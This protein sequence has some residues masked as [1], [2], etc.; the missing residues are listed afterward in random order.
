[1]KTK[2]D[3]LKRIDEL[4]TAIE[5][6]RQFYHLPQNVYDVFRGVLPE[7]GYLNETH[8]ELYARL[9]EANILELKCHN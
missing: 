8:N 1:M 3:Y 6:A 5:F 4:E 2:T 7:T 9:A